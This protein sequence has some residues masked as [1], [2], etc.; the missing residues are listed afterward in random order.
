MTFKITKE[1]ALLL[2]KILS[3]ATIGNRIVRMPIV[4]DSDKSEFISAGHDL[5]NLDLGKWLAEGDFMIFPDGISFIKE[6]TFTQ[7]Y[8]EEVYQRRKDK[9]GFWITV[10]GSIIA[11]LGVIWGLFKCS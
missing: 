3:S 8:K 10:L 11:A 7:L 6:H 5:A 9:I 2:D 4:K 1:R